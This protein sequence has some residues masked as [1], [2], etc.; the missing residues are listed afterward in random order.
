MEIH[1]LKNQS[2]KIQWIQGYHEKLDASFE[3]PYASR[4]W[5]K[6]WSYKRRIWDPLKTDNKEGADHWQ[7]AAYSEIHTH[8]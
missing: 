2:F 8:K 5:K 4:F 7:K 6:L 3:E 1:S